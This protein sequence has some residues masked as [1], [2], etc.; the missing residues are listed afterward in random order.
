MI[1]ICG[2]LGS[3][4]LRDLHV[5]AVA[6]GL[7]GGVKEHADR[8]LGVR[9]LAAQLLVRVSQTLTHR[10]HANKGAGGQEVLALQ[11]AGAHGVL[12]RPDAVRVLGKQLT[13]SELVTRVAARGGLRISEIGGARGGLEGLGRVLHGHLASRARH[14]RRAGRHRVIG[15]RGQRRR[16]LEPLSATGEQAGLQIGQRYYR[17]CEGG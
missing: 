5:S 12:L 17:N 16:A 2:F 7:N 14:R 8:H 6:V 1:R 10:V 3:S 4:H 13:G 15:G 11:A 9:R